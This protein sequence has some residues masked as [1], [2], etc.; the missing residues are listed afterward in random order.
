[1]C[2][3]VTVCVSG[4]SSESTDWQRGRNIQCKR[5]M[6]RPPPLGDPLG[7]RCGRVPIDF[8]VHPVP[9]SLALSFL[10][11]FTFTMGQMTHRPSLDDAGFGGGGGGG[12]GDDASSETGE[13]S[14]LTLG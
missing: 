11:A 9:F 5:C 6:T 14:H 7:F 3:H 12:R 13:T 2:V 1:M 4:E 10:F 8:H